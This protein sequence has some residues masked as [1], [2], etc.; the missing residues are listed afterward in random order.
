VELVVM[1][2]KTVH[3]EEVYEPIGPFSQAVVAD[4]WIF[5]SGTGGLNKDGKVVSEDV[6][7]QAVAML[8]NVKKIL[9]KAGGSFKNVLSVTLYLT[10]MSDYEKVNNIYK[11]YFITPYPSRT[12]VAVKELPAGEKVKIALIAKK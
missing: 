7:E 2:T 9:E 4:G 3:A 5:V 11:R 12:T 6:E 8:E 10:S 1:E